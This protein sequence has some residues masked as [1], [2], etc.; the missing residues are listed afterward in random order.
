MTDIPKS[1]TVLIAGGGPGG[2]YAT[3]VLAREGIDV[4]L[5]EAEKFPSVWK[6]LSI[7]HNPPDQIHRSPFSIFLIPTRV[8]PKLSIGFQQNVSLPSPPVIPGILANLTTNAL[9]QEPGTS[10]NGVMTL[11]P[12][13]LAFVVHDV[14]PSLGA[15]QRY[16][17]I[18]ISTQ[19]GFLLEK[20]EVVAYVQGPNSSGSTISAEVFARNDFL[21]FQTI[22][23]PNIIGGPT[24][25]PPTGGP[26]DF[27][28]TYNVSAGL[29]Y[30]RIRLIT[31][32]DNGVVSLLAFNSIT[33][34]ARSDPTPTQNTLLWDFSSAA[35]NAQIVPADGGPIPNGIGLIGSNALP[36]EPGT[37][38]NGVVPTFPGEPYQGFQI[39]DGGVSQ[40][41]NQRYLWALISTNV[42]LILVNVTA[43]YDFAG[44][45]NGLPPV[46]LELSASP[47]FSSVT[48]LGTFENPVNTGLGL[49]VANIGSCGACNGHKLVY[50]DTESTG[51]L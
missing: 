29:T 49:S 45:P 27:N 9:S 31:P 17:Y 28:T 30:L 43:L 2:S 50:I 12:S 20:I 41:D 35:L 24:G 19:L 22:G 32:S 25:S 15:N 6:A 5:L 21:D 14:G 3:S 51:V 34:S 39:H 13:N 40:G 42:P 18:A 10:I 26:S 47:S 44:L 7:I 23:G 16:P 46:A 4:V 33:L 37:L 8:T 48:L 36:Q 11:S 38:T 1:T